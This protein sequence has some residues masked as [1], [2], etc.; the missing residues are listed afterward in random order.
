[1]AKSCEMQSYTW[2][3]ARPKVVLTIDLTLLAV[4]PFCAMSWVLHHYMIAKKF[5]YCQY[6]TEGTLFLNR[7]QRLEKQQVYLSLNLK[8]A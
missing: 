2:H 6:N 5:Y 7:V 8:A 3:I 1:M 4:L